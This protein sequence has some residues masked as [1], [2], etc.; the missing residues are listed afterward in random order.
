[1]RWIVFF[2]FV[3][4]GLI[5]IWF[6]LQQETS[7]P[8]ELAVEAMDVDAS[9]SNI[10][11]LTEVSEAELDGRD[12]RKQAVAVTPIK[13]ILQ[14]SDV[15]ALVGPF[16]EIISARQTK[17]RLDGMGLVSRPVMIVKQLPVI[18]WVYV[19]P[20]ASKKDALAML[21]NMQDKNI[22]SFL[23]AD[24]EFENGISVGFYSNIESAKSVLAERKEQG[25]PV[26]LI[27]KQRE[28]KTF[29][30]AF[31]QKLSPKISNEML[32]GLEE[33]NIVIKKQEKSCN[34][35]AQMEIIE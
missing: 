13:P 20:R 4:N 9:K 14:E 10:V 11:L 23:I 2:L 24:G 1:M 26:E 17:G 22:D 29:W 16:L 6:S 15:C 32:A 19:P 21:R 3:F 34:E 7:A 30:L 25:Y 28:Q 31:D 18:N 12:I 33:G 5:F 27:E 8:V 35:V